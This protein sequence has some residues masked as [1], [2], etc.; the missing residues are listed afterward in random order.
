MVV[1]GVLLIWATSGPECLMHD[2]VCCLLL[3]FRT[4]SDILC[5]IDHLCHLSVLCSQ[6]SGCHIGYRWL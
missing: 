1:R 6:L 3:L 4:F 2:C 5:H